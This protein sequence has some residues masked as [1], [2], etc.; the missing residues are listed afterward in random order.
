[1]TITTNDCTTAPATTRHS[2]A[3][4]RRL[5]NFLN[6]ATVLIVSA[7]VA[8]TV[9]AAG[10]ALPVI[11]FEIINDFEQ[12]SPKFD[13]LPETAGSVDIKVSLSQPSTERVQVVI[14]TGPDTDQIGLVYGLCYPQEILPTETC[15]ADAKEDFALINQ[16]LTFEPGELSKLVPLRI[17]DDRR[18]EPN[19]AFGIRLSNAV[20]ATIAEQG[21]TPYPTRSVNITDDDSG[22][23]ITMKLQ[24][25]DGY[26]D[27]IENTEARVRES[28]PVVS[29]EIVLNRASPETVE[30]TVFSSETGSATAGED[31]VAIEPRRVVFA[32][33]EISKE[34]KLSIIDDNIVEDSEYVYVNLK[35]AYGAR[36]APASGRDVYFPAV[37]IFDNDNDSGL[38]LITLNGRTTNEFDGF[39]GASFTLSEPSA[40]AV[41]ALIFTRNGS[42]TAGEDFWGFS[43]TITFAPGETTIFEP[44]TILDDLIEEPEE[45]FQVFIV[46]AQN[47]VLPVPN[48]VTNSIL[49]DDGDD[50]APIVDIASVEVSEADGTAEVLLSLDKPSDELSYVVVFTQT[51]GSA[52]SGEDFWGFSRTVTF[53]PGQTSAMVEVEIIDD[54][55]I[56]GSE[57]F[58]VRAKAQRNARIARNPLIANI[59]ILDDDTN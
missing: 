44:V 5:R 21:A 2:R 51:P 46:N 36:I 35:D 43:R 11:G 18:A 7:S 38:P 22:N 28:T 20:N 40:E 37:R 30:V 16:R 14:A 3:C 13:D 52:V 12:R 29:Y 31:Y 6:I 8:S 34:V 32:P 25:T 33:G 39:A 54:D 53:Q 56:E 4:R 58:I 48:S 19:E 59:L 1:M 47:A 9:N 15:D 10:D 45:T 23:G 24:V 41:T 57:D 55:A 17:I 50:A 27:L 42:A 49:D 26:F